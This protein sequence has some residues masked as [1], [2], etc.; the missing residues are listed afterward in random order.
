[1]GQTAISVQLMD[2]D[3]KIGFEQSMEVLRLVNIRVLEEDFSS[4][5]ASRIPTFAIS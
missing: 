4:E 1:M 3:F 5:W 2:P